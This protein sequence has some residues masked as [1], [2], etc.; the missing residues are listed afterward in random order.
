VDFE[1]AD[2]ASLNKNFMATKTRGF[3]LNFG[4][5]VWRRV[6]NIDLI[7]EFE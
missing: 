6:E 2:I 4:Q 5:S 1:S 3:I 7:K